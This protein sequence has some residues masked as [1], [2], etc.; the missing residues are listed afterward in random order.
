[1]R[2][3]ILGAGGVGGLLA[4]ALARAGEDVIL[5]LR[6]SALARYPGAV[7]V[8]STVLGAWRVQV[9][10]TT[11][12]DAA[13]NLLWVATK[14]TTLADAIGVAA[15]ERVGDALVIPLLNGIDHL[16]VLRQHYRR[17]AAATISVESERIASGR[18]RQTSPFLRVELAPPT[19]GFQ[20]TAEALQAVEGAARALHEAGIT[21]AVCEN[22]VTVL[23]D[24]LAFLAPIALATTAYDSVLGD[25]RDDPRFRGCQEEA[26]AVAAASGATI[27]TDTLRAMVLGA[28]VGMRSSMQKDVAS[29]RVPELDAIAG[30]I[31]RGGQQHRLPVPNT[32]ALA[33]MVNHRAKATPIA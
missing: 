30:P 18:I 3:A 26:L 9:P 33:E 31:L 6:P 28:P 4:A 13:P 2:H 22:E 5:L 11:E 16:A 21:A 1:M 27:D 12:L 19:V 15:P 29:G 23:W 17:V 25:V 32:S 24:K 14:A 20:T 7:E 8:D 10:A